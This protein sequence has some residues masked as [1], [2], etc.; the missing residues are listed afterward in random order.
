M[1]CRRHQTAP[2]HAVSLVLRPRAILCSWRAANQDWLRAWRWRLTAPSWLRSPAQLLERTRSLLLCTK[3]SRC[4]KRRKGFGDYSAK[5]AAVTVLLIQAM[6][7]ALLP[8]YPP[9]PFPLVRG[10]K[11]AVF[12]ES[13]RRFLDFYGG[14]C[15]CG[16]GHA[17]RKITG[18]I[19][20]QASELLFYST[21][22]EVPVRNAAAEALVR[23]ANGDG[24]I[25]FASV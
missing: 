2:P 12:D 1:F 25:D 6:S 17:H 5:I 3:P 8:T 21:A 13:G 11:D 15:V 10:E 14:H 20:R 7:P 4:A 24:G 16:T 23:F 18:A 22:A 9:L 19:A